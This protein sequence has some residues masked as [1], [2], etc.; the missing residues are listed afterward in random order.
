MPPGFGL[1]L[2]GGFDDAGTTAAHAAGVG[3]RD[4]TRIAGSILIDGDQVGD[5]AATHELGAHGVA[6]RFR[7]DHDY[8]QIGARHH[9][10]V[11]D[12]EAVR[13]GQGCALLQVRLDLVFVQTPLELVRSQ[14]HHQVGGRDSCRHVT[15][16]E[17][18][19]LSLGDRRRARTQ[20]DGDVDTGI[21]QVARVRVALGAVTD[22][23][24]FLALDD[25][26]IAIFIV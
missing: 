24:D 2:E 11:V 16:L 13:E 12:R 23:G 4:V 25:R 8:V 3:Q 17:A 22:D 7:R 20:A 6:R 5:A 15:D 10:V 14:D 26:K 9:L 19:G 1:V 18:M 21:L